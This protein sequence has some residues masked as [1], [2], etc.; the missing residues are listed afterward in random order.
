MLD[1]APVRLAFGC[2][3]GLSCNTASQPKP[4]TG[5]SADTS[6]AETAG[7]PLDVSANSLRVLSYNVAVARES[8]LETLAE[9]IDAAAADV[10]GLQELDRFTNRS[11]PEVDQVAELAARTG[12]RS[13][14]IKTTDWDGGEFGMALLMRPD[15]RITD[16]ARV[17]LP[18][19]EPAEARWVF[20]VGIDVDGDLETTELRVLVTHLSA[21]SPPNRAAQA[22]VLR[23]YLQ[24]LAEPPVPALL[25]GDMNATAGSLPI[26]TLS[27]TWNV[28]AEDRVDFVLSD[29]ASAWTLIEGRTLGGSDHPQAASASDHLAVLAVYD[30]VPGP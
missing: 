23:D 21:Y 13:T 30:E 17:P 14:F 28:D 12:M 27:E 16:E 4:E 29:R 15:W 9:V 7:S 3:L 20:D 25:L 2:W 24:G 26:E 8:D 11:G 18:L 6:F 19:P 1:R 10:V 5:T 22:A